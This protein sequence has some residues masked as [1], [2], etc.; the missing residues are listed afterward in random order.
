MKN[1]ILITIILFSISWL[2]AQVDLSKLSNDQLDAIRSQVQNQTKEANSNDKIELPQ[3][4]YSQSKVEI[5]PSKKP[6]DNSLF[7]YDFLRGPISFFDNIPTPIIKTALRQNRHFQMP[8][9]HAYN[10]KNLKTR[11]VT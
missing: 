9:I 6:I 7:G 3:D 11:L 4:V 10:S 5:K 2:N 8:W 1:N